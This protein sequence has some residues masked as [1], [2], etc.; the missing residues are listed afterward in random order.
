M[1]C[2][3]TISQVLPNTY[4]MIQKR[5]IFTFG[6]TGLWRIDCTSLHKL[7]SLCR[8][9]DKRDNWR[10]AGEKGRWAFIYV[11]FFL[12]KRIYLF[13]F[14]NQISWILTIYMFVFQDPIQ[15]TSNN[16][17]WIILLL[18]SLIFHC[19]CSL[20]AFFPSNQTSFYYCIS[21]III[22]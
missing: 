9:H 21:M 14:D 4:Q 7:M 11:P 2:K 13:I 22:K 5:P 12:L 16:K 3:V 10:M 6:V 8:A 19:P 18:L 15:L 17:H 20:S 1:M